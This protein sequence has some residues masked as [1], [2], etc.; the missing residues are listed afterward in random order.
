MKIA[1]S[2]DVEEEGLF[3]G[4]YPR[5]PSGV[6][7]V[8]H[9]ERIGFVSREFGFPLTLLA[10]YPVLNDAS[11]V[12]ILH[13]WKCGLGAEIGAHLHPW[14]T[15]PFDPVPRVEPVPAAAMAPELLSAKI[16]TLADVLR[17]RFES[18]PRS[19]RMG[20]F[21]FD[22]AL[23]DILRQRGFFVDCSMVPLRRVAE[24]PDHFMVPPDPFRL[25]L[26]GSDSAIVEV[27]LTLVPLSRSA[28]RNLYLLARK[29][30]RKR[31]DRVLSAY[32]YIAALGIQPAWFPLASMKAA[33]LLHRRRGGRVLHMFL[34]S[35]EL[36]PGATPRF[37][38]ESAV[39]GLVAK[40]RAFL[41]WLV[42]TV[43][44]R[45][46]T[47]SRLYGSYNPVPRVCSQDEAHR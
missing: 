10:T 44:V 4:R 17:R 9:L 45:G 12:E 14:N 38:D 26:R 8:S 34:H 43:P 46:V 20:R 41:G 31:A 5:Q 33:V 39:L 35:S 18:T 21:D 1:V 24:G 36:A 22:P 6:S 47:L 40:V 23:A 19:F 13:S 25:E 3:S 15:P 2:I 29:M 42:N 30:H 28:S 32:R 11:C 16:G 37:R 27:P 7:N